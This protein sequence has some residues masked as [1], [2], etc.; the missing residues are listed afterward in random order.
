M[1]THELKQLE[2]HKRR[3]ALDTKLGDLHLQRHLLSLDGATGSKDALR[4]IVQLDDQIE[5]LLRERK[6]ITSAS[7]R[8]DQLI[9]DEADAADNAQRHERERLA[10]KA[11][12][13]VCT[14]N[15]EIDTTL[16]TLRDQLSRRGVLLADL[17]HT[18]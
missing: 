5:V 1:S 9:A 15:Q 14:L 4:Q 3:E 12:S 8:L 6:T 18:E 13:A 17:A 11:A 2:L 16:V 10:A 7:E